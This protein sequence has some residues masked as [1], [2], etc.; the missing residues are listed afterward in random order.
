MAF[1]G[2]PKILFLDEPTA[3]LDTEGQTL[4]NA[5]VR[6]FCANGGS[7]VLTS[8]VWQDIDTLADTI[9]VLVDGALVDQGR[10]SE[11]G[12]R[13]ARRRVRLTL[14]PHQRPPDWFVTQFHGQQ[15]HWQTET[16][17][18]DALVRRLCHEDVAFSDLRITPVDL[19]Q[20]LDAQ[21]TERAAHP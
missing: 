14:A 16:T 2:C 15:G 11:M 20:S 19:G 17:D 13:L 21:P 8:H 6:A 10:A 4:I 7:V 18:T 9:A 12:A 5:Q 1:I 3:G